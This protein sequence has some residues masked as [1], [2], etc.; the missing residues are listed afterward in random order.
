MQKRPYI[1]SLLL[2]ITLS[3]MLMG[4]VVITTNERGEKIKVYPDGRMEY[5]N[6]DPVETADGQPA[7]YPIFKG[8]IEPLDG[9]IN[10]NQE[11][12]YLIAQRRAQLSS[13]AAELAAQR[14]REAEDNFSRLQASARATI[15]DERQRDIL[16]KQLAAAQRTLQI[17]RQ[18]LSESQ[19]LA[20]QDQQLVTKGGFVEAFNTNRTQTKQSERR[21]ATIRASADVSYAQL[22]PLTDNTAATAF[23]DVMR[24]PP[25]RACTVAFE[26]QDE[27]LLQLRRDLTPEPLFSYT[28][29][30]LRPYLQEREYLSCEA[31]LSSVGGYRFLTLNFTFAYPNAREAYGF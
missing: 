24:R 6:G 21:S 26:G 11:D 8:Y 4:Q 27:E 29:E 17:S 1:L 22:I 14:V 19:S 28:D 2:S 31:Y 20:Q 15:N 7:T 25:R 10:V 13:T 18:Q 30:R 9:S 16:Q 12:L 3:G 23:E 5:F